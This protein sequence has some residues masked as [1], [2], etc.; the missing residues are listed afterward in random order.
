[1]NV[2][3]A[4]RLMTG[5]ACLLLVLL[6]LRAILTVDPYF[7][8]FAYHLPFAARLAGLCP[9]TC[10]RMGNYLE[11][12]YDGFPKLFHGMQGMVWK[13]TGLA[14][15][16]DILNVGALGLFCLFLHRWFRVPAAWTFCALLA[17]PLIQIHATSTYIDLPVNLAAAAA[18][19]ALMV[20][21]RAPETFG[22]PKLIGLVACLVFAGNCKP[23]MLGVTGP[24]AALFGIIAVVLL[25][26]GHRLGPFVPGRLGSWIGLSCFLLLAAAGVGVKLVDNAIAHGN[27][28][29]PFQIAM[30]GLFLDGPIDALGTP[31]DSLAETWRPFPPPLRWLISVL[32]VGAYGYREVP[33]TFDQ[34]YCE[35]SLA[36]KDCWR[37]TSASF[38][39]GGY[40]VPYV[41]SLVAFLGWRLASIP[42]RYRRTLVATF[43]GSTLLAA[44]LPRSHELRYYLFWVIILVALCLIVVFDQPDG[45]T[46]MGAKASGLL[47]T[48]VVAMLASV[49]LMT[50]ARYVTPIGRN[51]D[52]LIA[53]LGVRERVAAIPDGAVVCV[54]PGWQPFTFLFAPVFHPGR[55]YTV[56]DGYIGPCRAVVPPPT[57]VRESS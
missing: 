32:D 19:L 6:L 51:V 20:L 46:R 57:Q 41:L 1:M 25:A 3:V 18:I 47:G 40:F 23:Q 5:A 54:D 49:L 55:S 27:P 39:M 9:E 50:Q 24:V 21:V 15:A 33:W 2:V 10:Y 53:T 13:F 29:Y 28:F 11:A 37:P 52:L 14:Q 30:L 56:L 31:E 43:V 38:R 7:D 4:H 35:T 22:W 12:A 16:V 26:S 42:G 34:G 48:V 17:V 8:S 44:F 45:R 36:W